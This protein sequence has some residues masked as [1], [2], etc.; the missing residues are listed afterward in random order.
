MT[1]SF[2]LTKTV[3][4]QGDD[5]FQDNAARGPIDCGAASGNQFCDAEPSTSPEI[6]TNAPETTCAGA[7]I[8]QCPIVDHQWNIVNLY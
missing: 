4:L 8:E 3:T 6:S 1:Y 2:Q 7:S 5:I